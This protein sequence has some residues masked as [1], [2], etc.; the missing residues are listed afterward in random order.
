MNTEMKEKNQFN[1]YSFHTLVQLEIIQPKAA[2]VA[3]IH[4]YIVCVSTRVIVGKSILQ[5]SFQSTLC[6]D[7][8]KIKIKIQFVCFHNK[9]NSTIESME[10]S[11]NL[12]LGNTND[13]QYF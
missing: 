1:I 2:A 11:K 13:S 6:D 5:I 12:I 8:T 9:S 3:C 10:K 7:G 4:S